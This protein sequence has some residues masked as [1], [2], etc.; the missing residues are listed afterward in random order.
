MDSL[1]PFIF[2]LLTW[3]W[4][5][6]AADPTGTPLLSNVHLLIRG[7][8]KAFPGQPRDIISPRSVRG[9][10]EHPTQMPEPPQAESFAPGRVCH[11]KAVLGEGSN[12]VVHRDNNERTREQG[13]G[14]GWV[15]WHHCNVVESPAD[16]TGQA[17]SWALNSP[18]HEIN[19]R[20]RRERAGAH[21]H[22]LCVSGSML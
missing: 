21:N 12:K 13:T 22:L 14:S 9:S 16:G 3:V 6:G 20:T 5:A 2:Q 4:V 10:G 7:N 1:R 15:C 8:P 19:V 17:P 11:G 18:Q